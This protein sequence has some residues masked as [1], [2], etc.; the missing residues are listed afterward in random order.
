MY[1]RSSRSFRRASLELKP[2]P[3]AIDE[4]WAMIAALALVGVLLM[5]LSGLRRGSNF[6][7]DA[8]PPNRI[9]VP[10]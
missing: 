8:K 10:E 5:I 1:W 3:P 4:A 6:T 7:P 9:G 2:A